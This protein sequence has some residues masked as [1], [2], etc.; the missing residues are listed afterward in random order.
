VAKKSGKWRLTR[1]Q[2]W[3][4]KNPVEQTIDVP[5][6]AVPDKSKNST[7]SLAGLNIEL[8]ATADGSFAVCVAGGNYWATTKGRKGTEDNVV[9]V[10]DL[11][12]FQV[13]TTVHQDG[14]S[15]Y[16]V[17]RA[18]RLVLEESVIEGN[19]PIVPNQRRR[20]EVTLRFFTLPALMQDGACRFTE[21]LEGRTWVPHD[22]DCGSSL[23]EL[24]QGLNPERSASIRDGSPCVPAGLTRDGRLT[25][26]SCQT[27][28]RGFFNPAV[29]DQHVNIFSTKTGARVG[30]VKETTRDSV[31]FRF[32]ENNGQDYVLFLEGGTQLKVYEIS[33]PHP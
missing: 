1:G 9:S 5:G 4:D 19:G 7:G 6:I 3:L 30:T 31:N 27:I 25:A 16:F 21:T 2:N 32:A 10:V 28:R 15:D 12:T 26:E 11:R 14:I 29:T 22:Q 8:L 17:D 18:G 33:E 20:R 23:A 13:L 24:L